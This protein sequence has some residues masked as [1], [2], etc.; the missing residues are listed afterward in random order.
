MAP[1]SIHGHPGRVRRREA[2]V[3]RQQLVR[4]AGQLRQLDQPEGD[5]VA[6]HAVACQHMRHAQQLAERHYGAGDVDHRRRCLRRPPAPATQHAVVR[7]RARLR[8]GRPAPP[9]ELHGCAHVEIERQ[10][11]LDEAAHLIPHLR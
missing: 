2:Q 11:R 9:K 6:A 8:R 5:D 7:A 4:A 10:H 3:Q 1:M